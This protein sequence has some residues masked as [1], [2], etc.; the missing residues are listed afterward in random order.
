MIKY[1][2]ITYTRTDEDIKNYK[3]VQF[4]LQFQQQNDQCRN[5]FFFQLYVRNIWTLQQHTHLIYSGVN[6]KWIKLMYSNDE[7]RPHVMYWIDALLVTETTIC[8]NTIKK[9]I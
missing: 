2:F 9:Y 4:Q 5:K 6:G 7:M 8:V 1:S 3:L